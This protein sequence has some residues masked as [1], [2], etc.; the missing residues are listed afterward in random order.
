MQQT[1]GLPN[2]QFLH[3]FSI[4]YSKL[5]RLLARKIQVTVTNPI[6]SYITPNN[7]K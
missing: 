1:P 6:L 3:K 7:Q 5:I 4:K 2:K